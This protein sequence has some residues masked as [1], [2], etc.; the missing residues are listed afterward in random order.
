MT[1]SKKRLL[2]RTEA[3]V[4]ASEAQKTAPRIASGATQV[5]APVKPAQRQRA[6]GQLEAERARGMRPD[7][8]TVLSADDRRAMIEQ[9]AYFRAERRGFAPGHERDD[10]VAAE[11]EVDQFL[12]ASPVPGARNALEPVLGGSADR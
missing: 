12:A 9:A 8:A 3:R 4:S 7:G 10:W 5:A 6:H 1:G 2:K 11:L